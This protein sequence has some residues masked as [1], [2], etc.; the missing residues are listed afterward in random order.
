MARKV[1]GDEAALPSREELMSDMATM[2]RQTG[3]AFADVRALFDWLT[4]EPVEPRLARCAGCA[5]N[6]D[7]HP[8]AHRPE[9]RLA[10]GS[11]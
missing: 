6:T 4:E 10:R 11:D 3:E 7:S 2:L 1:R 8:A 9:S 5:G